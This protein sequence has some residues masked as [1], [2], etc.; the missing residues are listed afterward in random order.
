MGLAD[1]HRRQFAWRAWPA[2]LD[3][4]P[5]LQGRTVLDLG[6]GVG[7]LAAALVA[8]GARVIGVDSN[9]QLLA[10]ARARGLPGAEFRAG[11][12]RALPDLGV[13]ADG[14]WCS[15][16]AAYIPDLPPVLRA[17]AGRLRSGGWIALTEIDGL[18][19]HEPLGERTKS[20]LDAYVRDSLAAGR[21]DFRMGIRLRGHLERAGFRVSREIAL[22]DAEFSFEGPAGPDVVHAWEERLS[23]MRLL[24]DSCG[25]EWDA[26]RADFLACLRR[27][28][29]NSDS[30]VVCCIAERPA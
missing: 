13:A 29:H 19:A 27:P 5:P 21:Y 11:D 28:D 25:A 15:F 18:F 26:V 24:R 16:A 7:D 30:R 12:L 14:V 22:P 10:E 9:E 6:C 1:E 3:A 23:R 17:W 20:L 2:A 8:R 4:L